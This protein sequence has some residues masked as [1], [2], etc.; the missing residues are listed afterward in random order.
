MVEQGAT[1]DSMTK[2]RFIWAFDFGQV[3]QTLAT[4]IPIASLV[5]YMAASNAEMRRDIATLQA[6]EAS[7]APK[8]DALAKSNDVQDERI[9]NIADAVR[10]IQRV[11]AEMLSQIGGVREDL[12]GIKAR[13]AV[14]R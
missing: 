1:E 8:V 7:Y 2:P 6:R 9:G 4:V 10:G 3:M 12:A 14:P 11:N 13:I 5:W